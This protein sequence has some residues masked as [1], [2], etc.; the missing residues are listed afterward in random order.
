MSMVGGPYYIR[1]E[2]LLHI[3]K[4]GF[5]NF[6]VIFDSYVGILDLLKDL[7]GIDNLKILANNFTPK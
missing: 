4:V 7:C 2:A 6:Q 1:K 5:G 3:Y